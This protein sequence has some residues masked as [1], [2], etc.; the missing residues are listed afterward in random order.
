MVLSGGIKAPDRVRLRPELALY[1]MSRAVQHGGRRAE[2]MDEA[3]ATVGATGLAPLLA[4]A[5]ARRQ[6][7]AAQFGPAA[8]SASVAEL[9]DRINTMRAPSP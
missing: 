4:T 3:A 8:D 5:C 7:W 2:E 1:M 6:E 9:V